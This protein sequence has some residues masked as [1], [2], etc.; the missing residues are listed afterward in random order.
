[1][2]SA[3]INLIPNSLTAFYAKLDTIA[4]VKIPSTLKIV[5]KVFIVLKE[6]VMARSIP[7]Q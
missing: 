5:H 4:M 1:M 3:T 7:A 2:T 6:H